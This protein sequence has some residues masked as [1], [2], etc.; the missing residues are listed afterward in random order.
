MLNGV[1]LVFCIIGFLSLSFIGWNTLID[2]DG[3]IYSPSNPIGE[4]YYKGRFGIYL[5]EINSTFITSSIEYVPVLKAN[6]NT[7]VALKYGYGKDDKNI[8]C[9]QKIDYIDYNS[10]EILE[11]DFVKDKNSIHRQCSK[12]VKMN[13]DY[14]DVLEFDKESFFFV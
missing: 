12:A 8:Y 6:P 2:Y 13:L 7:F 10:F 9:C 1:L 4:N 14:S 3:D 11:D 5:K